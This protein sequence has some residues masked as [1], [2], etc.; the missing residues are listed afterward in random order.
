LA[1]SASVAQTVRIPPSDCGSAALGL[2]HPTGIENADIEQVHEVPPCAAF[3][4]RQKFPLVPA[5]NS[6]LLD[7]VPANGGFSVLKLFRL[8]DSFTADKREKYLA[9]KTP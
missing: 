1:P 4:N 8:R 9:H 7:E 6:G 2:R 5:T 3:P